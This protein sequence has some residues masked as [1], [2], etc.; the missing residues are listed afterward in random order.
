MVIW[1]PARRWRLLE[2]VIRGARGSAVGA[3]GAVLVVP[4]RIVTGTRVCWLSMLTA[5]HPWPGAAPAVKMA[6]VQPF[7]RLAVP[8]CSVPSE[9]EKLI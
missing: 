9:D 7:C 6:F 4:P 1:R 8:G 2:A 3:A 5:I